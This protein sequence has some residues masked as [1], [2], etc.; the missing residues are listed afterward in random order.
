[1]ALTSGVRAYDMAVRL[2]Y[3]GVAVEAIEPDL[4]AALSRLLTA[5]RGRPTRIFCTYTAMMALRRLLAARFGLAAF[6][7]EPA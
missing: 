6:G 5:Y 4:E 3:D 2:D 7:E 1:M